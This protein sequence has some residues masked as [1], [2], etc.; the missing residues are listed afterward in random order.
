MRRR[1]ECVEAE[2]EKYP[3]KKWEDDF[4]LQILHEASYS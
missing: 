2:A 1:A 4:E 3:C